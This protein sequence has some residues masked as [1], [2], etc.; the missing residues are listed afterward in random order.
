MLPYNVNH[1]GS[2]GSK[3]RTSDHNCYCSCKSFTIRNANTYTRS[4][5]LMMHLYHLIDNLAE[6]V[7]SGKGEGDI[8]K[9]TE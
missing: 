5:L 6:N 2:K 4:E 9:V 7:E 8:E 3:D 1:Y